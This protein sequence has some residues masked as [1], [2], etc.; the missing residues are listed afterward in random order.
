[1]ILLINILKE[2]LNMGLFGRKKEKAK[3]EVVN[4]SGV[5]LYDLLKNAVSLAWSS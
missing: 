5:Q 2:D 1:M 3:P 4:I